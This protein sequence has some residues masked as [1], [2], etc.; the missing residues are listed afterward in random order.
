MQIQAAE[1]IQ[2]TNEI[3]SLMLGMEL[4]PC[5]RVDLTGAGATLAASVDIIGDWQA[6][7]RL[8]CSAR[9][10]CQAAARLLEADPATIGLEA[11]SD[12]LAE[13]TNMTA[14]SVKAL[15]SCATRL[16][17]PVM[18][19]SALSAA[20]GGDGLLQSSFTYAGEPLLITIAQRSVCG[21]P[22]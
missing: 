17:I 22:P 16:T 7:V 6:H 11:I 5:E 3:W 20:N 8:D 9:L 21:F 18:E 19:E 2:V 14:G 13:L 4:L 12:A 15:L 10:A 1:V